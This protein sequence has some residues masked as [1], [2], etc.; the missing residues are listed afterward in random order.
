MHPNSMVLTLTGAGLLWFGWFGFNGGSAL[1][2]NGLAGVGP[3]GL[4]GG[5]G[6]GGPELDAGRV[7]AQGQADGPGPGLRPGGRPGGRDAGFRLCHAPGG[8]WPSACSAGVVCYAAVCLKPF[9]KYDDSLD[10]FGVHGVGGFLGAVLT[11]VFCLRGALQGRR[12]QRPARASSWSATRPHGADRRA[13][14][15]RRGVGRLRVRRDAGPGQGHR[16]ALG[17]HASSRRRRTRAWTAASTAKS[18][19]TWAWRWNGRPETAA[20]EPRPPRC[21]P[22]AKA[23]HRRGRGGQQRRADARLVGAVPGRQHAAAAGVQGRLSLHDH[24]PGQPLPLPRRRSQDRCAR[25]CSCSS[26]NA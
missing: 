10:A 19:S 3:G 16:P 11:G 17:L 7:V 20:H 26:R 9:F 2:A 5:G 24:G 4:A 6:G 14:R 25:T 8:A 1:A 13:V 23:L 21:R 15:R 12:R 22:T 18:A